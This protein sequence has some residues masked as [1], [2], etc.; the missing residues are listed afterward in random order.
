MSGWVNLATEP[1]WT[2]LKWPVS[3]MVRLTSRSGAWGAGG[4]G[5]AGEGRGDGGTGGRGSSVSR[6]AANGACHAIGYM[7]FP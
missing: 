7:A 2:T 1:G 4:G 5:G 6:R 3:A